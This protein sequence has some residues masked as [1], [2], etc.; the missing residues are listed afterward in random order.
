MA[1]NELR[2]QEMGRHEEVVGRNIEQNQDL[3]LHEKVR[4]IATTEQNSRI[5]RVVY[6]VYA[7]FAALEMLL[8]IRILLYLM[9]A[10]QENS[11]ATLINTLSGLFVAPFASLLQNPAIG[12]NVLEIT[13]MIAMIVYALVG[14]LVG[15]AVW[16]IMS[17]TR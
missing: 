8:G 7:L 3:N 16:L 5:A 1:E 9:G 12:T 14:L 13:T 4:G 10:N 2:Q 15:R 6:I 11:F 17:R